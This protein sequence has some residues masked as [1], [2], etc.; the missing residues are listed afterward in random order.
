[1]RIGQDHYKV[2]GIAPTASIREIKDAYR[3]QAFRYHADRNHMSPINSQIMEK[4]NEAYATLSDPIKR[5]EYDIPMGY[6]ILVPK[7]EI[8]SKVIINYH[9]STPFKDHIGLIVHEPVKDK[10]RFWYTVKFVSNMGSVSLFAEE[11]LDEV[12][13]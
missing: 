5:T 8:G 2:L 3:Q 9:S 4:I 6:R 7:F 10:F 13:V 12:Q 1:M 11:E